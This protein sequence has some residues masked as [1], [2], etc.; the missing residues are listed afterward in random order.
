MLFRRYRVWICCAV[1]ALMA[2]TPHAQ[3]NTEHDYH[4]DKPFA[5]EVVSIHPHKPETDR[6]ETQ[7]TPNGLSITLPLGWMIQRAYNPQL[8]FYWGVSHFQNAPA[9]LGKNEY[10][11]QARVATEDLARWQAAIADRHSASF[12]AMERGAFRAILADRFHLKIHTAAMEA[13]YLDLVVDKHGA[14][15]K[16]TVPGAVKKVPYKTSVCGKGFFIDDLGTRQ[17]VGVT[18]E[19]LARW[20][21][22]LSR[23][24]PVQDKTGLSGRYDFTLPL[25][26]R[27]PHAT[28][29]SEL[30]RMPVS[31]AGLALK[32]GKGPALLLVIDHIDPLEEN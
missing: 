13:P 7:Y 10:D 2:R 21:T 16:E 26:E 1:F 20:L 24:L 12:N 25:Y 19:D 23:D 8:A 15:L 17:F 28:P 3:Q 22:R 27:D 31:D 5:F 29:G 32:P 18:M 11:I 4:L 6:L 9:W 14:K 30:V